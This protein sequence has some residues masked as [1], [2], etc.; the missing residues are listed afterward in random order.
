MP[1]ADLPAKT[2]QTITHF[3]A[4]GVRNLS[5]GRPAFAETDIARRGPGVSAAD[6][7][8][9]PCGAAGAPA[10]TGELIMESL[11]LTGPHPFANIRY[12]L[13]D[14]DETLTLKGRLPGVTFQALERLQAAGIRIVPVTAAPAGWCDQMARMWPVDG[15]IGEN[16][17]LFIQRDAGGHG[18]T[19]HFWPDGG[20]GGENSKKLAMIAEQV[21]HTVPTAR[22]ADDQPFR[23]TSIAFARTGSPATDHAIL[24][25]IRQAG[26][27]G[28]VNNLWVLGWVGPYDKLTA[29]RHFL[30][31]H[32]GID[33]DRE[34]DAIL[35][36]GDS[37][38]DAPMFGFFQHSVGVSTVRDHLHDIPV[39]PRWI[40]AGPGGLGFVEIADAIL[41]RS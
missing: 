24:D 33:I 10:L 38:N 40:T 18:A 26:G 4:S 35:Y 1:A 21:R 32:A 29:A 30:S 31:T 12:V 20:A 27:S 14:M 6:H 22:L 11:A 41:G 5:A 7:R 39:P 34:R 15:V 13:T 36:S 17:G 37:A 9:A 8:S 28:T 23:L 19:R 25:A 3:K 2:F 16:G